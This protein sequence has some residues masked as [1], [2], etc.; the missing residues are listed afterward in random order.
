[1]KWQGVSQNLLAFSRHANSFVG[2]PLSGVKQ[3]SQ[4]KGVTSA[5]DPKRTSASR[6]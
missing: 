3:T 4:F 1:M 5:Y 2:C 6:L